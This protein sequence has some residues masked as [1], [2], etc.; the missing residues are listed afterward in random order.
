MAMHI[1]M[2]LNNIRDVVSLVL[3]MTLIRVDELWLLAF[4]AELV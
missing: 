2:S 4:V 1:V 3:A